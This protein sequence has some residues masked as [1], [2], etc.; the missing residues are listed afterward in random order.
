[1]GAESE[2]YRACRTIFAEREQANHQVYTD[3]HQRNGSDYR[4]RFGVS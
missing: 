4:Y 3:A 1:M 2:F